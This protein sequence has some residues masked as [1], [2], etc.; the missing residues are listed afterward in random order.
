MIGGVGVDVSE[1]CCDDGCIPSLYC[2]SAARALSVHGF[3]ALWRGEQP[4]VTELADSATVLALSRA[5]RLEVDDGG[6]LVG[7]HGLTRR[8]T[9]HRVDHVRDTVHTWCAL[10]AI[11]IPA[12]LGIDATVRTS[13]PA[14][15]AVLQV[16][17]RAGVPADE[18]EC[19][20]WV[21]AGECD[22]LV[23]DFCRHANL[24]CDE[25]HL[26]SLTSPQA[27]ESVTVTEAA[28]M[29]RSMWHD[30]AV[31]LVL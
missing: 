3:V 1:G 28:A 27:G 26:R 19:R 29:G 25:H 14:C 31:A 23:D 18:G 6:R 24:F 4:L 10:D 17:V 16:D 21:P 12:A 8:P 13:C 5:G 9:R 15:G 22:H 20:L 30:G 11:G 2:A 7:V